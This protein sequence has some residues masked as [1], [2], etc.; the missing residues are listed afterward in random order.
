MAL[1]LP[2]RVAFLDDNEDWGPFDI[3]EMVFNGVFFMDIILNFLT[4]YYDSNENLVLDKK[5][6][7]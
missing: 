7:K 4:A 3:A 1:I 6:N 5:V 2:Y